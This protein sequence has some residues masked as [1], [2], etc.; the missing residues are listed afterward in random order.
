MGFKGFIWIVLLLVFS[1]LTL[2]NLQ[3]MSLVFFGSKP[4]TLPLSIWILLFTGAGIFSS[5]VIYLLSGGSN[6]S[7]KVPNKSQLPD[8]NYYPSPP[9]Q[10]S[11]DTPKNRQ[12]KPRKSEKIPSPPYSYEPEPEPDQRIYQD[13]IDELENEAVETIQV[14]KIEQ[15]TKQIL[16]DVKPE[17]QDK[18]NCA[19]EENQAQEDNDFNEDAFTK[20]R[21]ASLYSYSSRE[22]TEIKP[23]PTPKTRKNYPKQDVYDADYRVILPPSRGNNQPNQDE[24]YDDYEDE[25]W[26]F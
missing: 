1:I 10:P 26:D 5:L 13:E 11:S 14:E 19:E 8:N 2:Q 23:K 17:I 7:K 25:N 20:P 6:T 15:N 22:R 16:D 9:S 12:P 21:P 18:I 24:N 3:P 4:I